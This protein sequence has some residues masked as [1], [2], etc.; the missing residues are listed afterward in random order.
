M[1]GGEG[2]AD[3]AGAEQSYVEGGGDGHGWGGEAVW[4]DGD[5]K[6]RCVLVDSA[7]DKGLVET[8]RLLVKVTPKELALR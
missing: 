1:E 5:C 4:I 2:E 8:P 3:C 7:I 6:E